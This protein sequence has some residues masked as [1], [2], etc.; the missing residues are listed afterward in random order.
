M[1][2]LFISFI[3]LIRGTFGANAAFGHTNIDLTASACD[4]RVRLEF[5]RSDLL[6][7]TTDQRDMN[8][9]AQCTG[10]SF[11]AP[12]IR[13]AL[14]A[15]Q[16]VLGL[17]Q[18]FAVSIDAVHGGWELTEESLNHTLSSL[19]AERGARGHPPSSV[20][21][22]TSFRPIPFCSKFTEPIFEPGA[23]AAAADRTW[24]ARNLT[25][26]RRWTFLPRINR[27]A[28]Q[29]AEAAGIAVTDIFN[30]SSQR[31]DGVMARW[32]P[33][34]GQPDEDCM[35]SCMPGPV[36]VYS[37]LVLRSMLR[38]IGPRPRICGHS[39]CTDA[40]HPGLF[41]FNE[42]EWL[43]PSVPER[44]PAKDGRR[45]LECER[46][47]VRR[48]CSL[49]SYLGAR[50]WWPY[51]VSSFL[52]HK[53]PKRRGNETA[54]VTHTLCTSS[55]KND[56]AKVIEKLWNVSDTVIDRFSV[57]KWRDGEGWYLQKLKLTAG[58]HK[59]TNGSRD[60]V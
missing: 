21:L 16:V 26:S 6:L 33:Q 11:S 14:L 44:H 36:D 18:H 27:M 56:T 48:N 3:F 30:L 55:T 19:L 41:S 13:R 31:P 1:S 32:T 15:D 54:T 22:V 9:V 39:Q 25:Y 57:W 29:Q 35:H 37:A 49:V 24:V 5:V 23:A 43:R 38:T 17:G 60:R 47:S 42:S 8:A 7:W 51:K 58:T 34:I 59:V 4:S 52:R 2:Q 50:W 53:V 28:V 12:F 45:K 46:L 10:F 20:Q 40:A